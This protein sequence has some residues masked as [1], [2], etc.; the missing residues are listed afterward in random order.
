MS[1]K[2]PTQPE[3]CQ[4]CEKGLHVLHILSELGYLEVTKTER[5][6]DGQRIEYLK[7]SGWAED[8]LFLEDLLRVVS[9]EYQRMQTGCEAC[10]IEA[11]IGTQKI[12]HPVDVRM[13]TCVSP[14]FGVNARTKQRCE[15]LQHH[16]G[17]HC[18]TTGT[19]I[20]WTDDE[21]FK[22]DP[23]PKELK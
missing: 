19:L 21:C 8:E 4:D 14:C 6:K 7:I 9:W 3:V 20:E 2:F 1:V 5:W 23:P 22:L 15:L 12:P 13:H 11:A 10:R 18:C 17:Q 16:K